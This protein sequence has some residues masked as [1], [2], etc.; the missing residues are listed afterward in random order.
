MQSID[1]LLDTAREFL[2]QVA[3]FLPKLPTVAR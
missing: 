3:V 1:L 2:H